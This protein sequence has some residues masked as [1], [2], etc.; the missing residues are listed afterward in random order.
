M[1]EINPITLCITGYSC[2]GWWC[3]IVV[4]CIFCIFLVSAVKYYHYLS[5]PLFI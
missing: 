4:K 5:Q 3:V 1:Q 2:C